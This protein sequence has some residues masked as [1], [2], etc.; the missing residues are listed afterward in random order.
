MTQETEKGKTDK[1]T[2][3][4]TAKRKVHKLP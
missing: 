1:L 4:N 3:L 2:Q